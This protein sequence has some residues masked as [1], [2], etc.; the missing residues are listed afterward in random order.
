MP[1]T[2]LLEHFRWCRELSHCRQTSLK[3][4]PPCRLSLGRNR[5][6][7]SR[8]SGFCCQYR[9][10]YRSGATMP[11]ENLPRSSARKG[12]SQESNAGPSDRSN[13]SYRTWHPKI[14]SG[15]T[16][17][18]N[19]SP[20]KPAVASARFLRLAAQQRDHSES[21]DNRLKPEVSLPSTQCFGPPFVFLKF[22]NLKATDWP[23]RC[24]GSLPG[25]LTWGHVTS[26]SQHDV[27]LT[28]LG[29]IKLARKNT[30]SEKSMPLG[31]CH[32]VCKQAHR[33]RQPL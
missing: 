28:Y 9:T 31:T 12:R 1:K 23:D 25:R 5:L 30:I 16:H 4:A 29:T 20:S 26:I 21:A 8:I 24:S 18:E 17:S 14:A 2:K 10:N 7:P 33:P 15:V 3:G 13:S 6:S 27:L 22:W 32:R 11:C 19:S